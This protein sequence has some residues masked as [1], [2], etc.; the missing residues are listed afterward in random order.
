MSKSSDNQSVLS[1]LYPFTGHPTADKPADKDELERALMASVQAKASDSIFVKQAFFARHSETLL[2]AAKRIATTYA[3]QGK[4]L[5]AGNGGSS[6]DAAHLAVEFMHPVTTGRR[7][8]PAINLSQ[9]TAMMT[10]VSNDVGTEHVLT[11][12]LSALA[13]AGDTLVVFSTSGNSANL[14][15]A[16]KKARAMALSVIA[17]TGQTGGELQR[18]QL[19][20]VCITVPSDSI[21]RIQECHLACYHILWDLVHSLLA[22]SRL[23][24]EKK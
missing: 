8:L 21:H 12:Q 19:T 2:A 1:A 10:A 15:E 3:Q 23:S 14:I 4:L 9:D 11:R 5:T 7:A 20:D 13:N 24:Q 22:D 16:S 17:F 18:Q 6:C